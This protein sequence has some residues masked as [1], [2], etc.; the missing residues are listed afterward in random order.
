MLLNLY[1][2]ILR[3]IY[4]VF[5]VSCK[6][7]LYI[8]SKSNNP[9]L[10]KYCM[11]QSIKKESHVRNSCTLNKAIADCFEKLTDEEL[12]LLEENHVVLTY[13]KGENLCKQGTIAS[14]IM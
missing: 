9:Y 6:E 8:H 13:K 1:L 7:D 5:K 14:H 12:L 2:K 10:I 3:Y 4:T 11:I